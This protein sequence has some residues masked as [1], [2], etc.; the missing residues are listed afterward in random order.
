MEKLR[1]GFFVYGYFSL[2]DEGEI[3]IQR[4]FKDSNDLAKFIDKILEKYDD[5]PSKF[6]TGEIYRYFR[7]FKR[8]NMSERG[9]RADEFRII[10]ENKCEKCYI[11]NGNG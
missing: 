6:Y 11:P 10:L 4:F 1:I 9:R 7:N 3:D 8:I 5:H 2:G